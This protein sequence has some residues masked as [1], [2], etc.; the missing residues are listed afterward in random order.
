MGTR[1]NDFIFE[2]NKK[3]ACVRDVFSGDVIADKLNIDIDALG[4][5]KKR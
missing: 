4:K 1:I 5:K 2:K 3:G